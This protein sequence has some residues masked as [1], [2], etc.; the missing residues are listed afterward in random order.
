MILTQ[1]GGGAGTEVHLDQSLLQI[2]GL[3]GTA[4]P[5]ASNTNPGG[6]T[7]A[8]SVPTQLTTNALTF[9][10]TQNANEVMEQLKKQRDQDRFCDL[11]LYVQ[12]KEFHAH[13]NVLAACSPYFGSIFKND[14]IMKESL[15]I[16][17]Q[18]PDIFQ[19]F[20]NYMYTGTVTIDKGN[21]GELLRLANHFLMVK[22]KGYCGEYLERFLD[23]ENCISMK[24]VA[25]RFSMTNLGKLATA[26]VQNHLADV[27]N[28]AAMMD[29]SAKQIETF[30][31][32]KVWNL[33]AC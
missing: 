19:I 1:G 25:E 23:A 14:R 32:E 8:A 27:I 5:S 16:S 15:A 26:F 4:G 33:M 20:L 2:A 30:L 9:T 6:S 10:E 12:G 11:I 29:L 7:S 31:T 28:H 18:E 21:V 24:E 13:R 3:T 17:C 22:L